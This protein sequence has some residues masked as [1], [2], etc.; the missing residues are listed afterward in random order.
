FDLLESDLDVLCRV[1]TKLAQKYRCT[2]IVGRTLM[3][4]A[5]PTTFGVK[6]AGWLDAMNRH[7]ERFAETR[8]RVL[9]L[10]FG[11]AVGTLAALREKGLQVAEALAAELHLGLPTMPWHTQRDRVAEAATTLGLCTGTLGKIARDISLHMQ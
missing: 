1:L 6:V 10:Q 7:R 11:G 5:L 8:A 4:H 2:P 9:V 3:Q